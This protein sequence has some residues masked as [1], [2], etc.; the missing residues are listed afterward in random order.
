MN[1]TLAPTRNRSGS[2]SVT[3][4]RAPAAAVDVEDRLDHRRGRRVGEV[5]D[6]VGDDGG[7]ASVA[8]GAAS[9]SSVVP[10]LRHTRTGGR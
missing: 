10:Q 1:A 7:R 6:G 4:M 3:S 9:I 5:V 8:T 2:A